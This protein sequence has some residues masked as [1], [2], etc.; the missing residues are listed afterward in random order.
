MNYL[1]NFLNIII[2]L[3]LIVNSSFASEFSHHLSIL[4][5]PKYNK[6]FKN[7]DYVDPNARKGVML[8]LVFKEILIVLINLY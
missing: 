6:D 2:L 7:F 8:N 4:S 3:I 5:N 1:K